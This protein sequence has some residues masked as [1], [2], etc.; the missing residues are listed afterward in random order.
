ME[1]PLFS[2]VL[3]MHGV[4]NYVFD[5]VRSLLSQRFRDFELLLIDDFTG[6]RSV[7]RALRAAGDDSRVRIIHNKENLG[8]PASR[9]VG[10]DAARGRYI[11][12]PDAEDIAREDYLQ[13]AAEVI[14]A[15]EPDV[16][17]EGIVED[18]FNR[19][20]DL[21]YSKEHIPQSEDFPA[22]LNPESLNSESL[23]SAVGLFKGQVLPSLVQILEKY[24]LM[25]HI[26]TKF[27]KRSLIGEQRFETNEH[28]SEDFF[29]T[30]DMFERSQSVAVVAAAPYRYQRHLR[31]QKQLSL[32]KGT[33]IERH[34]RV[35][36]SQ[37]HQEENNLDTEA[38]R[39]FLAALYMRYIMAELGRMENPSADIRQEERKKW[40]AFLKEDPL[41]QLLVVETPAGKGVVS[42]L[43][44]K[45]LLAR[46]PG[47]ALRLARMVA[48]L[49]SFG[50]ENYSRTQE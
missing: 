34:R 42:K 12:F 25:H 22:F 23:S 50:P 41:F 1:K 20:G 13:L 8:L 44:K 7:L 21:S 24:E 14:K 38:S 37:L 15:V 4:E 35:A 40:F 6:D 29:F 9:N 3:C 27:F 19:R 16:V 36:A 49:K 2:L 43:Y 10:I 46:H 18:F 48:F 11:A 28:Y 39:Q 45:V 5:A 30:L 17:V 31:R 33:F 32:T 26:Y 47:H